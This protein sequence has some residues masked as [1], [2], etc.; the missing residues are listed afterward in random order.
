MT[1]SI[2]RRAPRV[3]IPDGASVFP[4]LGPHR[5]ADD[6]LRMRGLK[7]GPMR[8]LAPAAGVTLVSWVK[9]E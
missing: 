8:L 5:T 2:S 7:A 1:P 6:V 9:P 4:K 3:R